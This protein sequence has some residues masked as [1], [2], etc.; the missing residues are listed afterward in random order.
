[1][2]VTLTAD[3]DEIGY[4]NTVAV[5]ATATSPTGATITYTWTRIAAPSTSKDATVKTPDLATVLAGTAAPA[6][7]PGGYY[8]AF[9]QEDRFGILPI[10]PDNKGAVTAT[11]IA[12][13]GS[14]TATASITV[15][16][17][18]ISTGLKNVP[19]G[20]PVYLNSGHVDPNAWTLT[21]CPPVPRRRSVTRPPEM[22]L[23]RRTSSACTR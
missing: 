2:K 9:K 6:S 19:I 13:D 18:G 11:V 4:G 20:V 22:P 23:L 15:N 16:A 3:A 8:G 21:R 17:A 5:H 14:K 10:N 1:M 12:S 7:D